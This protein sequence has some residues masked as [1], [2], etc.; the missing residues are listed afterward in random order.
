VFKLRETR[1]RLVQLILVLGIYFS[2]TAATFAFRNMFPGLH[3]VAQFM[4]P[5]IGAMLPAA[6]AYTF[7]RV[8]EDARLVPA[9][10]AEEMVSHR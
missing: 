9:R 8:P 5:L 4:G 2:A 3:N 10:L 6:W 7:T 1:A